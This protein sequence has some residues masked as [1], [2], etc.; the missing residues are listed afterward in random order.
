MSILKRFYIAC[1]W[2][3]RKNLL[4][5]LEDY[6][7]QDSLIGSTI[8]TRSQKNTSGASKA[9]SPSVLSQD[10]KTS[11]VLE[12]SKKHNF[13]PKNFNHAFLPEQNFEEYRNTA[14]KDYDDYL[15]EGTHQE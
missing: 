8:S 15:A 10:T 9:S 13:Y 12:G 1:Y 5:Y 4:D 2:Q 11:E 14:K 7:S 6:M 3:L